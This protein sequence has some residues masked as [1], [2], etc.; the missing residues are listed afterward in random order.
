[1]LS[2][3]SFKAAT[4]YDRA[5]HVLMEKIK[6]REAGKTTTRRWTIPAQRSTIE[7]FI[8]GLLMTWPP[9]LTAT[10]MMICQ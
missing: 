3:G 1:M 7:H 4:Y 9:L 8:V 2:T 10:R 5:E 6:E